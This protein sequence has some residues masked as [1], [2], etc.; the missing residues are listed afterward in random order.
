MKKLYLFLVFIYIMHMPSGLYA[1]SVANVREMV[2][3]NNGT[4]RD[5]YFAETN[6]GTIVHIQDLH[7]NYDAQIA[8]Y[9]IINDLIDKYQ[10]GV[11]AIE[12]SIGQL[13]TAP[14]SQRPNDRIK[15]EVAKYFLKSG[16]LDGA[17]F[18]HMMRHSGFMFWGADDMTLHQENVEAYKQS[19]QG[20]ADNLKYY[21]NMR[22][23]IE[24]L[25]AKA[26]SKE[27]KELDAKIT[28]YNDESLDFTLYIQ[29]LEN[30]LRDKNH[31]KIS[32]INFTKLVKVI[33]K[34][35][36]I[37][38]LEVDNQ[39]SE[40][41]DA[42]SQ[43]L[44]QEDLSELLDKNL[45]FKTGKLNPVLFYSYLENIAGKGNMPDFEKI[46]PQ[47][48][49]Y[50]SYIK[51]YSEI[52]NEVLFQ[53]IHQIEKTIKEMLFANLDQRKIDRMSY[54]LGI[55]K[56]MFD[57]KLTKETLQY[58]R[59]NRKEFTP[60][61]FINY[62]SDIAGKYNIVYK[63]DPVFR[64]IASRF[65]TM[66][67]FYNLAE[68][69]DGILVNNTIDAMRKENADIAVLVAGG[70]HTDGITKLLKEQG[71]SYI[72]VT[73]RIEILEP[74]NPY[75]SVLLDEKSEFEKFIEQAKQKTKQYKDRL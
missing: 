20:Q 75:K 57:L 17:G 48:A 68:Q 72:V 26:Y 35:S 65:P 15:E 11:V 37:D 36:G 3:E 67:R 73:P 40:Y 58:Y 2:S 27:L 33:D 50:I 8:I 42:L 43:A 1:Q 16:Q 41:M 61:F 59:E 9:N 63:L 21:D 74:D 60:S 55:L 46:Y 53:E 56:D 32:Y 23:I 25:K 45:H 7:C 54:A 47:L 34:E 14:Y 64:N 12:G 69:R 31:E 71:M 39:R 49:L 44:T 28:A 5:S 6:R 52:D 30:L 4:I 51:L 10:L 13:D 38:F 62:I 29:Y 24:K 70:F 19:I 66:E 18:A 22:N